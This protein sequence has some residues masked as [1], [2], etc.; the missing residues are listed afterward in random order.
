MQLLLALVCPSHPLMRRGGSVDAV[1]GGSDTRGHTHNGT[2][3]TIRGLSC[4]AYE[5]G[6]A[7]ARTAMVHR[8]LLP[9]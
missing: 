9:S 5:R 3:R 2:L 6:S 1:D 8:W 7:R 4:Q